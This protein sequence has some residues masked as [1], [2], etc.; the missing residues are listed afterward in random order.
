MQNE[1]ELSRKSLNE[2][3]TVQKVPKESSE[4]YASRHHGE[5]A[6]CANRPTLDALVRTHGVNMNGHIRVIR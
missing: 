5:S 6:T 2:P 1:L 4:A 3:E